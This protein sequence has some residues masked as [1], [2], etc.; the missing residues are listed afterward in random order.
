MSK[1]FEMPWQLICLVKIFAFAALKSPKLV[2]KGVTLKSLKLEHTQPANF[3]VDIPRLKRCIG[4]VLFN[5][6]V[7]G[8]PF[9]YV[10]LY[11]MKWRG[12][13]LGRDGLPTFH[14]ALFELIMFSLVEEVFFY[15]SHRYIGAFSQFK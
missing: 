12:C 1:Q 6:T 10:C 5:Q 11:V 8:I 14:W 9:A 3:Q 13:L 7:I 2:T 15:Y 4:W